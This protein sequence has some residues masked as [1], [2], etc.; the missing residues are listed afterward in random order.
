MHASM[1][2]YD[3]HWVVKTVVPHNC[4]KDGVLKAHRNLSS[5]LI[6]SL[7]YREIVENISIETKFIQASV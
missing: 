6:A 1:G 5:S 2:K 4:V 7:F 3:L